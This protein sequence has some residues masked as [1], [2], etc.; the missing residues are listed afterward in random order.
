[1]MFILLCVV[2]ETRTGASPG[3][4][5]IQPDDYR[6][7][8]RRRILETANTVYN[9]IIKPQVFA[10][11]GNMQKTGFSRLENIDG[12][13]LRRSVDVMF[14]SRERAIPLRRTPS[15]DRQAL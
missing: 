13:V 8:G 15:G 3:K 4:D 2:P 10:L 9:R 7:N 5:I 1:M 11:G 6:R 14:F 12:S